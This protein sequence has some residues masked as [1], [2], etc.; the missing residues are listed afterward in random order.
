LNDYEEGSFT[1]VVIGSDTPGTASYN[2]NQ[3]R[4]TKVGRIVTFN[5]YV[6]WASGTGTGALRISGL[7]FTSN[8]AFVYPAVTIGETSGIS[9]SANN[10]MTARINPSSTQIF[11]S[12][13]PVGGGAASSVDYD[14]AGYFVLA[15]TYYV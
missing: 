2:A 14:S 3:G 15:G 12:Q 10:I 13:Y 1:P 11:I 7:P 9:A 6:D 5:L 8:D 4:Y